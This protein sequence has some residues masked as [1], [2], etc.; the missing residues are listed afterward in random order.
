MVSKRKGDNDDGGSGKKAK[1]VLT[2]EGN[3]TI[4]IFLKKTYTMID[5]CDPSICCWSPDGDMFVI[6]DQDRFA[7]EIIPQYFDHNK[8]SSF[9]RQLN[10]YGCFII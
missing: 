1:K 4:P 5:T 7:A 6:K 2:D 3:S 8:F 10:F 9:A